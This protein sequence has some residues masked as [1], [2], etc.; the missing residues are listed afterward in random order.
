M[1]AGVYW[2]PVRASLYDQG[3]VEVSLN[4]DGGFCANWAAVPGQERYGCPH[5]TPELFSR[6]RPWSSRP[7]ADDQ[8]PQPGHVEVRVNGTLVIPAEML[9]HQAFTQHYASNRTGLL[10][11]IEQ[12][13]VAILEASGG[14]ENVL[15]RATWAGTAP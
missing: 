4:G 8:P 1:I 5:V 9:G 3:A 12:N 15:G 14:V 11:F 2:D 6:F 7:G 10:R 13:I